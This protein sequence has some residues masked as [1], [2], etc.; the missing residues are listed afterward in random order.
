MLAA[1]M[2]PCLLG[3]PALA[4]AQAPAGRILVMPFENATLERRIVW[5]GEASAVL[6]ADDLNAFGMRAIT[7]E[8]RREAFAR[9]Q[10]PLSASLTD[11]TVIRIGQI[12]GASQVV[13]GAVELDGDA[14]VVRA[15]AIVIEAGRIQSDVTERGPV[16]ELFA[17]FERVARRIIAPTASGGGGAGP[18]HPPMGA[19]ENYIKGLLAETPATA[20]S[21]LN[22]A[23]TAD[24]TFNRAR[25]ALWELHD[26]Q[27]EHERALAAVA[28]IPASADV[29]P[30]AI[31]G[32]VDVGPRAVPGSVDGGR[33]ARFLTGLSQ[34]QLRRHDEAFTT[35][36]T[37]ADSRP[38]APVLNNLG[39]VQL[40]RGGGAQT[41][42]A[43]YYF[44]AAVEADRSDP[45]YFFNLGY[46]YW[47]DRDIPAAVYWLREAVR[48]DPADGDAHYVLG[49]ALTAAG[50]AV[51]ASREKEL[52][53]R[54]SST[55]AEWEKRPGAEAVPKGLERL[56]RDVELPP[57]A[58]D[59]VQSGQRD[60][61]ELARF[62]LH[63]GRRLYQQENDREALSELNRAIFLSPY[64]ADAHLLVGRI[65]LR[66]GRAQ[67]AIDAL[68]ISLWS[69]ETAE[70][71]GVLAEALLDAGQR[72]DARLEAQRA[73]ALDP[74]SPNAAHVLRRLP[75][76]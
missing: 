3:L 61:Q 2:A 34:L 69:E 48:R 73:I 40:R 44:N 24:P 25:L 39:V 38:S 56:K 70:A 66:G 60:H 28:S 43:T 26:D 23:L 10:V 51:E 9:I 22:A 6:L 76:K 42:L 41:G 29:G 50:S 72:D 74:A 11:A 67:A 49:A 19:F 68:K 54:L 53:K 35:F 33:R 45:D 37:L 5:L 27:G 18:V 71:H 12:V 75:S 16:S 1:V 65:H 47:S 7:R 20:V 32:S 57:I 36:K 58:G 59:D 63:R 8:E 14:L 64:Q 31:P 21:Y 30:R 17:I 13:V 62:H 15:R 55:Y 4:M 52:A 46:A